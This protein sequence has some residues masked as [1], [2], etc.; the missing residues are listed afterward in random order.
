MSK[1]Q[2]IFKAMSEGSELEVSTS[3]GA[4]VKAD[5]D[6]ICELIGSNADFSCRVA[7]NSYK[8]SPAT[9]S[10]PVS[11]KEV[12]RSN[13]HGEKEYGDYYYPDTELVKIIK[14]SWTESHVDH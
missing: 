1:Y 10:A 8:H 6:R 5:Y 14:T 3:L 11:S 2:Q 13:A 7:A 4:W 9:F 12:L